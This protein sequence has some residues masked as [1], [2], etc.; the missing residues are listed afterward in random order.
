[1]ARPSPGGIRALHHIPAKAEGLAQA[2]DRATK[3]RTAT[4]GSIIA[5]IVELLAAAC[6]RV[7]RHRKKG[8]LNNPDCSKLRIDF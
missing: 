5:L 2:S 6:A 7:F 3:G 1:V 8:A 4:T